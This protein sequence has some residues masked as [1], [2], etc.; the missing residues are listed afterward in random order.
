MIACTVFTLKTGSRGA[1]LAFVV[2]YMALVWCS[3]NRLA[4][5]ILSVPFLI[6]VLILMPSSTRHRLTLIFVKPE[7]VQA[8][9]E[10]DLSSVASQVQRQELMKTAVRYSITHPLLG[11]GPGQF[12]NAVWGDEHR[13]GKHS[14]ALGTHNTYLEVS[15]ECGLPAF[16]CY[17]AVVLGCIRINYRLIKKAR[18][19]PAL[20]DV[21]RMAVVLFVT[22]AGFAVNIFFHHLAYT[23]NLPMLAGLTVAL[24]AACASV[25]ARQQKMAVLRPA[26]TRAARPSLSGK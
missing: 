5:V 17:V 6:G 18:Q 1:M 26:S 3:R 19:D 11:V 9:S 10:D 13:M 15:S 4:W 16:I 21:E 25:P 20:A 22:S 23:G 7:A 14:P 8:Q 2:F 12:I 24:S